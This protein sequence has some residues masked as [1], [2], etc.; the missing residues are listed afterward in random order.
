MRILRKKKIDLDET[1]LVIKKERIDLP[2]APL[3]FFKYYED[4]LTC[5]EFNAVMSDPPIPMVNA[6]RGLELLKNPDDRLLM[7]NMQEPIVLYP[8]IADKYAWEVTVLENSDVLIVF[9]LKEA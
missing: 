1:E 5:Y 9:R 6:L 8:R 2:G 4:D 7:Y 3:P